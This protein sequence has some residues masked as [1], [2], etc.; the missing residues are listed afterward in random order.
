V[1]AAEV[2]RQF[3]YYS[4]VPEQLLENGTRPSGPN[5]N[6]L[7]FGLV[8]LSP[9]QPFSEPIFKIE[10]GHNIWW[11][12]ALSRHRLQPSK[13]SAYTKRHSRWLVNPSAFLVAVVR[14]VTSKRN[15]RRS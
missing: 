6:I 2:I 14:T 1:P 7:R 8:H 13:I 9:K 12:A 4:Q 3:I 5:H 15:A 11:A 10:R